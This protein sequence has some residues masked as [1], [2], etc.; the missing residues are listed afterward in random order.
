M[1][2]DDLKKIKVEEKELTDEAVNEILKL[3]NASVKEKDEQISTLTTERDSY[4]MSLDETKE[5]LNNLSTNDEDL[6]KV[7]GELAELKTKY[8]T[9]TKDLNEKLSKNKYDSKVKELTSDLK[10]SSESAKKT[11]IRDLEDKGLKLENDK[12]LGFDDFVTSYKEQDPNAFV[13]EENKKDSGVSVNTGGEH[14][15][16][17]SNADNAA[18]RKAFGLAEK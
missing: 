12:I 18:L 17:N 4:K 7:K 5:K 10:F 1:K 13:K 3:Y 8:E 15:D 11:F 6:E 14:K 9:D 2:R 16:G